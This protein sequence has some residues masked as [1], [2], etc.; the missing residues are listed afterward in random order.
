MAQLSWFCPTLNAIRRIRRILINELYTILLF[1]LF[2]YK[3][4]RKHAESG[5]KC[6][7][8]PFTAFR[9]TIIISPL[10]GS[11]C[12][13]N[14]HF[15]TDSSHFKGKAIFTILFTR[16]SGLQQL[17]NFSA[18]DCWY[19]QYHWNVFLHNLALKSVSLITA[20]KS[21]TYWITISLASL[22]KSND[23]IILCF[24]KYWRRLCPVN[25]EIN[26][27]ITNKNSNL[28]KKVNNDFQ[29]N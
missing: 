26:E 5:L 19:T 15:L 23:F 10:S 16:N 25:K 21:F 29:R 9:N 6:D 13:G 17:C 27:Q 1:E 4:K 18:G 20:L 28:S 14:I 8:V 24:S 3:N 2:L 12:L 11:K 22:I 7:A